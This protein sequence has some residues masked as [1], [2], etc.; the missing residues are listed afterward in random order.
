VDLFFSQ[1]VAVF[2]IKDGAV[3]GNPVQKSRREMGIMQEGIPFVKAKLS[4]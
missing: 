3:F 1:A 2:Q 4:S